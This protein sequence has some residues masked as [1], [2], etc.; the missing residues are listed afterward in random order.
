ME[1][2]KLKSLLDKWAGLLLLICSIAL[3][4]VVVLFA[5]NRC[6]T[7]N[8]IQKINI[9]LDEPA[10]KNDSTL[11]AKEGIDSLMRMVANHE[12][13]LS[14]KYQYM[15]EQKEK[16]ETMLSLGTILVGIVLSVFGFFGFKS[17]KAIE[18]KAKDTADETSTRLARAIAKE[19]ST[20]IAKETATKTTAE[21]ATG[22]VKRYLDNNLTTMLGEVSENYF[23]SSSGN[24][25]KQD[26]QERLMRYVDLQKPVLKEEI[27]QDLMEKN[28][29]PNSNGQ[30]SSADE[31][32]T[33]TPSEEVKDMEGLL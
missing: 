13:A 26:V 22:E 29:D 33:Q 25:I 28:N 20:E 16:D 6:N 18:D 9:V 32:N 12:Q 4:I 8:S 1:G 11:Y 19:T 27:L 17:M 2:N 21:I 5:F 31:G 24:Q 15:L 23:K 10:L 14:D 30:D 7:S 3:V